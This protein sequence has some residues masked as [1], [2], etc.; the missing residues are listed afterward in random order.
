MASDA[1][2]RASAKWN[3][4]NTKT[5]CLRFTPASMDAYEHLQ[6][7]QNKTG[8]IVELI[9]RDMTAGAARD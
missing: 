7:Q 5:I 2:K 9:R 8:Y 6:R 3:A 1:Q 4:E